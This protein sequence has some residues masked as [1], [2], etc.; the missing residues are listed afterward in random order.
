MNNDL[1]IIVEFLLRHKDHPIFIGNVL[2]ILNKG[3]DLNKNKEE[4]KLYILEQV[5]TLK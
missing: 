4:A 2:F 1:N 3:G 5:K